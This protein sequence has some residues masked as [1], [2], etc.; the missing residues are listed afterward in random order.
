MLEGLVFLISFLSS[1]PLL[2]LHPLEVPDIKHQAVYAWT[3]AG[4]SLDE[5]IAS[6]GVSLAQ[7]FVFFAFAVVLISR[8]FRSATDTH[9][10]QQES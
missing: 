10:Q 7:F 6:G 9:R 4:G 8:C 5:E 3:K 2:A 1:F